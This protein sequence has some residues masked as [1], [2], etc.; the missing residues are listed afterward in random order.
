M[1]KRLDQ[2]PETGKSVQ[3]RHVERRFRAVLGQRRNSFRQEVGSKSFFSSLLKVRNPSW[4]LRDI[5]DLERVGEASRLRL[6]ETIEMPA[7]N[8]LVVFSNGSG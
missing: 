7:N 5:A 6:R 2:V 1:L 8:R 4:G 3:K